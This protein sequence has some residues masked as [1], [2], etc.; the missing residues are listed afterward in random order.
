MKKNKKVPLSK[1]PFLVLSRRAIVGWAGVI[2]L[3]CAWMFVIGVLVG[4]GTAPVEFDVD[5]LQKAFRASSR[6][7]EEQAQGPT[8]GEDGVAKDKT[9]LDFYEVLKE[10]RE[11]AKFDK[12]IPSPKVRK[13]S[14]PP[15]EK[16]P[17]KTAGKSTQVAKKPPN[18]EPAKPLPK[19]QITFKNKAIPAAKIYTIQAASLKA[20]GAA[21]KLVTEL[22]SKGFP[23]YRA[24]GKVPGKGIW[25]RVRIGEYKSRADARRMLENLKKAGM[26]PILVEK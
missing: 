8:Q 7:I 19:Q 14:E 18:T 26:K 20:A 12:V 24:M 15:S 22:K 5:K 10:D 25:Y 9:K 1:K 13:K 23:A 4:R 17:S 16:K 6:N 2:F 21:D 3:I 11:D